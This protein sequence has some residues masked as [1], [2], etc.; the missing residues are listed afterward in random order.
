MEMMLLKSDCC[1]RMAMNDGNADGDTDYPLDQTALFANEM[2]WQ[3][4][5]HEEVCWPHKY[6]NYQWNLSQN[7]YP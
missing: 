1:H 5:N 2:N 7:Y 3:G 6:Q 4:W